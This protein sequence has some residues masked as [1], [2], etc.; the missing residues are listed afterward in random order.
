[1]NPEVLVGEDKSPNLQLQL[2]L[3]PVQEKARDTTDHLM[4][5]SIGG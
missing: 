3:T 5:V 2:V 4:E 1:M